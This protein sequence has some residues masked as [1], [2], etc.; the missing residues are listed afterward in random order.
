M[1]V[2]RVPAAD[3]LAVSESAAAVKRDAVVIIAECVRAADVV[4]ATAAAVVL[5]VGDASSGLAG[6]VVITV[7]IAPTRATATANSVY[8]YVQ[9]S[10][11]NLSLVHNA[12]PVAVWRSSAMR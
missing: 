12:S 3:V 7:H 2:E 1:V 11:N 6:V 5:A 4:V 8:R 10:T 9:H